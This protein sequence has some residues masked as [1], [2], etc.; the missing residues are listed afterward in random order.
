[1]PR[2][3]CSKMYLKNKLDVQKVSDSGD[4]RLRECKNTEFVWELGKTGFLWRWPLVELSAYES[5][6]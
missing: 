2:D 5:V 1:M 4:G 6:R 3:K